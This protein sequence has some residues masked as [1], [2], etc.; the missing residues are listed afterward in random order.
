MPSCDRMSSAPAAAGIASRPIRA[1][2]RRMRMAAIIPSA[3]EDTGERAAI[4]PTRWRASGS[5]TR[6][7]ASGLLVGDELLGGRLGVHLTLPAQDAAPLL[8]LRHRH[9]ALHAHP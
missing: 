1:A 5:P 2:C 3:R 4:S 7:R 8:V 9:P 6:W